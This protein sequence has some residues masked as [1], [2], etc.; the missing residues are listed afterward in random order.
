[1]MHCKHRAFELTRDVEDN[2]FL[3][4]ADY[5]VSLK[6]GDA[7]LLLAALVKSRYSNS[8]LPNPQLAL[9]GQHPTGQK[10]APESLRLTAGW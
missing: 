10:P 3:Q 9:I 1:M 6:R 5:G 8:V 2:V 4:F 7:D